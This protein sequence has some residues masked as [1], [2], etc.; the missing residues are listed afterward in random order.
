MEGAC[1]G[2]E[3]DEGEQSK[4]GGELWESSCA[5]SQ[6]KTQSETARGGRTAMVLPNKGTAP[7]GGDLERE[8]KAET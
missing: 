4:M 2:G 6:A 5:P 1:T 8:R 7:E 3:Q